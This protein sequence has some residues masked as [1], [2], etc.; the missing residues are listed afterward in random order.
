MCGRF[1]SAS[2]PAEIAEYF[3]AQS[4]GEVRRPSYNVAP[5]SLI[6]TIS[7]ATSVDP[8]HRPVPVE[9]GR[10]MTLRRWGLIPFWSTDEK[11]GN[12]LAN[13]R[14]ETV[15]EK[16]SFRHAFRAQRCLIPMDGFY[17]WQRLAPGQP[18]QPYLITMSSGQPLAV[19]GLWDRWQPRPRDVDPTPTLFDVPST[20]AEPGGPDRAVPAIETC[21]ILTTA[22][23]DLMAPIHHR[24]PVLLAPD[25]W[26]HWLD[27][28]ADHASLRAL[29][30]PAPADWL[31]AVKVSTR[32][33][34]VR[35]DDP[36]LVV[37]VEGD[38]S[39]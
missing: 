28:D 31:H 5:S 11:I 16:P 33:N 34:S 7:H 17:E 14:S 12:K 38:Q 24:M 35:N 1:L 21:S 22:S 32:V 23:N 15:A 39:L 10:V 8:S 36:S 3:G 30:Q 26:D 2:P 13:A 29:M 4:S 20:T 19:G 25:D 18:K 37:P 27:P 6:Y 9:P